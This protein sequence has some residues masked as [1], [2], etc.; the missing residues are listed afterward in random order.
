MEW[1]S[2]GLRFRAEP[3]G[4][5][6]DFAPEPRH[7]GAPGVLHGGMAAT[8]LDE[9]MAAVGYVLDGVHCVTATLELRYRRPVPVDGT[10]LRVEGWRP[11]R[12]P[13]RHQRVHGRLLLPDGR[14]AVEATGIFVQRTP[15]STFDR[16]TR[17]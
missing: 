2:L 11:R 6:A 8:C 17:A 7:C 12:E 13:R 10:T 5:V 1:S 9:T 14:V 3:P 15:S 4:V 16:S